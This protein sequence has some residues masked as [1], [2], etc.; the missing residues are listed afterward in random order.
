MKPDEM[1]QMHREVIKKH[2]PLAALFLIYV[3]YMLRHWYLPQA[4]HA[5]ASHTQLLSTFAIALCIFGLI[6]LV[7]KQAPVRILI[8]IAWNYLIVVLSSHGLLINEVHIF[9]STKQNE[10]FI[11]SVQALASLTLLSGMFIPLIKNIPIVQT[12]IK[13]IF[14]F[15]LMIA[16]V[17]G[18]RRLFDPG[19]EFSSIYKGLL[20]LL[21]FLCSY[22]LSRIN[23]D[24]FYL[25]I[26]RSKLFIRF[27][28]A[29]L[30]GIVI[31]QMTDF[32]QTPV[33]T[34]ARSQVVF[35]TQKLKTFDIEGK[36]ENIL[37]LILDELS[38]EYT[39][40]LLAEIDNKKSPPYQVK[41][42][43]APTGM[44]TDAIP[45]LLTGEIHQGLRICGFTTL[46]S[47][48]QKID[49]SKLTAKNFNTDV[50]GMHHAYCAIQNLRS[51]FT[52]SSFHRSTGIDLYCLHQEIFTRFTPQRFNALW[53]PCLIPEN[54]AAQNISQALQVAKLMPFWAVGGELFIHL[55]IPHPINA[56]NDKY[57][58]K[59]S[60]VKHYEGNVII[61]GK[62]VNDLLIQL[63]QKF[64]DNFILVVTSDHPLRMGMWCGWHFK[65]EPELK[66]RQQVV[67]FIIF[68]PRLNIA[69]N[70]PDTQLE[71]FEHY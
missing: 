3:L 14:F 50:V 16:I 28:Y 53:K 4:Y 43:S 23:Y 69:T 63:T 60:L 35:D 15:P 49:F 36:G 48:N 47:E 18:S 51:C 42:I 8:F 56:G 30:G 57:R 55:P 25:L 37:F 5:G 62:I 9:N 46:C 52:N 67:P 66:V 59:P 21:A 71:I 19:P 40:K 38:P 7:I 39:E 12:L 64:K 58:I 44:T 45:T 65:C 1:K 29:M 61:A 68:S 31:F 6:A 24:K 34:A 22:L 17:Q 70:I 13:L 27:V 33:F 26:I 20:I 11:Y 54:F 32:I 10:Y 41:T 2:L